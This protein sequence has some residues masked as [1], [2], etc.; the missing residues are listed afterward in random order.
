MQ[1]YYL[2]PDAPFFRYFEAISPGSMDYIRQRCETTVIPN[3]ARLL[4]WAR[5]GRAA[6]VYLRLSGTAPDRSD[7][8]RFF[9]DA[10]WQARLEGFP[11]LYP[12]RDDPMSEVVAQLAPLPGDAV[13][14]KTTFSAFSSSGIE[15]WLRERRIR[16]VV[17]TGLATSQ[18][19]ET[20]ARDASDRG[21]EV[22]QVEDAQADYDGVTHRASLFASRGVCGG[23]VHTT[24]EVLGSET[25]EVLVDTIGSPFK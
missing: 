3:I 14:C 22:I 23:A 8:H 9:R 21:F 18:C 16:T 4:T 5:T 7:L 19:V 2:E 1:R 24:A 13:L 20:T 11:D 15:T 17:M 25:L 6:V 12:T 10:D